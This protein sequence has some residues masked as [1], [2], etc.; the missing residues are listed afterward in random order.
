MI[1]YNNL[2]TSKNIFAGCK[3]KSIWFLGRHGSRNPNGE[4]ISQMEVR[5]PEIQAAIIDNHQNGKGMHA[6]ARQVTVS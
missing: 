3:A 6:N 2:K 4:E 5:G 1:P